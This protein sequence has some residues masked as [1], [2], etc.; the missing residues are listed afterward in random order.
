MRAAWPT[1]S[2][3]SHDDCRA[4]FLVFHFLGSCVS[5]N[6]LLPVAF[7]NYETSFDFR[8]YRMISSIKFCRSIP[9]CIF[10]NTRQ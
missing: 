10:H 5:W 2:S 9:V 8:Q 3:T 4:A 7:E 6:T 1:M